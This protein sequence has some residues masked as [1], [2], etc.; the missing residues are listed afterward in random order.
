MVLLPNR[1]GPSNLIRQGRRQPL[2]QVGG[3][4]LHHQIEIGQTAP[5]V[6]VVAVQ[7]QI[8]HHTPHQ[9]QA[10]AGRG[11]HQGGQQLGGYVGDLHGCCDRGPAQRGS[12]GARRGS[13]IFGP[14]PSNF[15]AIEIFSPL[16]NR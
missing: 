14:M 10:L 5:G 3:A 13:R 12:I 6:L 4:A 8:P 16:P 1:H 15:T 2:H 7:Q 11:L 9:R